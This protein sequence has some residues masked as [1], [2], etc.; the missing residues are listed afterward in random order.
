[1]PVR[2][3]T[4]TDRKTPSF[5]GIRQQH[6]NCDFAATIEL[7]E[8]QPGECAGLTVRQSETHFATFLATPLED[9]GNDYRVRVTQVVA[10]TETILGEQIVSLNPTAVRMQLGINGQDY[11]CEIQAADG[12]YHRVAT[13]DGRNLDTATAGGFLGLWL[14]IYATSF[15]LPTKSVVFASASY[16]FR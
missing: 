4:L 8:L 2:L 14:G 5:L 16:T 3:E 15:G 7:K 12:Q 6:I 1:M 10:G 13:I 11:G 9:E